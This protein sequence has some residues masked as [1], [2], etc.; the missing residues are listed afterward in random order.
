MTAGT[1]RFGPTRINM[2]VP[3]M[4]YAADVDEQGYNRISLG[5][6]AALNATFYQ[7]A[8]SIASASNA[9]I[10]DTGQFTD[11][12]MSKFGRN[13][14]AVASG[15]A[16]STVTF[17]GFDY[18]GQK[19]TEILTLNGT[20]PVLGLK[21]FKRVT[22]IAWGATGATTINTGIGNSL[23]LPY[24]S[25][26]LDS[27][28]VSGAVPTAGTLTAGIALSTVQ[29]GTTGDPRGTYIANA[30]FLPNA[31]R[32]YVLVLQV[33]PTALHGAAHFSA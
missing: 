30:S 24:R 28:L 16:T 7:S 15:A 14:T 27:D 5:I 4:E 10:A 20:T 17:T 18:L 21:A 11:A 2:F 3:L 13:V 12:N 26:R 25:L 8:Q 31:A 23:G 6:P 32:D 33:D 29:S 1:D 9:N 19:I 22:N